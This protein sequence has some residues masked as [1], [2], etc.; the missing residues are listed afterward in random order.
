[1]DLNSKGINDLDIAS[2]K[3]DVLSGSR[4]QW[5]I[6]H[7]CEIKESVLAMLVRRV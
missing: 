3:L 1:V 6:Y 5:I 7:G 4:A 2:S